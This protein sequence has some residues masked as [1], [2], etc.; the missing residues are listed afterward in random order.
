MDAKGIWTPATSRTNYSSTHKMNN[1][2]KQK[3]LREA[4]IKK[5]KENQK[6]QKG[7]V[8]RT[9]NSNSTINKPA[10]KKKAST[11][12]M[13]ARDRAKAL[14]KKN[15]EKG[16]GTATAAKAN[17]AAMKLKIKKAYMAKKKKK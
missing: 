15:K 9:K 13:S 6:L 1:R 8:G 14:F 12:G 3:K 16:M 7:A 17:K 4:S 2:E 5:N 11:K 10:E